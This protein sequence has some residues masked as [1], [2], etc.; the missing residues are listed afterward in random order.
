MT[1]H[2]SFATLPEETSVYLP[3]CRALHAYACSCWLDLP[4]CLF[5]QTAY[6]V[7]WPHADLLGPIG[8]LVRPVNAGR[9][10]NFALGGRA[11]VPSALLALGPVV[12]VVAIGI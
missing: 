5:S 2:V 6:V 10:G 8:D 1:L 12:P 9:L 11:W 4:S 3:L 7:P